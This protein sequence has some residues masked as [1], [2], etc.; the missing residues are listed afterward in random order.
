MIEQPTGNNLPLGIHTGTAYSRLRK[1][2]WFADLKRHAE[3]VCVVCEQAIE[4]VEEI[5]LEHVQPWRNTDEDAIAG[6]FWNLEN[7]KYAHAKCNRQ[8]T[9]GS[10][11][12]RKVG[13]PG[14]TWCTGHKEFLPSGEFKKD[15]TRWSGLDM[16]CK[17]CRSAQS[18]RRREERN[19]NTRAQESYNEYM[20][21]YRKPKYAKRRKE[22]INALGAICTVCGTTEDLRVVSV[23]EKANVS[24]KIGEIA[25]GKLSELLANCELVCGECHQLRVTRANGKKPAKGTHGTLSAYRWCGP[26]KCEPCKQA[27]RDWTKINKEK[28]A[29]QE[30]TG[31]PSSA[32]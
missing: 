25:V 5:T 24:T 23:L 22:A 27:K 3:N 9:N 17:Q 15:T 19:S 7:V 32:G 8:T 2:K 18:K 14:T 1:Q 16:Y 29:I 20:R 10:I 11:K 31:Q 4:T 30:E 13:V 21:D 26:T 28:K 6:L 12:L